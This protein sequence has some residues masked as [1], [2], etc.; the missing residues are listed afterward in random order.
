[1][2]LLDDPKAPPLPI[3]LGRMDSYEEGF[4]LA[5]GQ[6][7]E[8]IPPTDANVNYGPIR[9]HMERLHRKA[10]ARRNERKAMPL[11]SALAQWPKPQIFVRPTRRNLVIHDKSGNAYPKDGLFVM[12]DDIYVQ[13]RI[14]DGSL[15]LIPTEDLS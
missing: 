11:A 5:H 12:A 2:P 10:D 13:R 15:T 8:S 14:R 3:I 9:Q 7:T 4:D 6:E 1:L